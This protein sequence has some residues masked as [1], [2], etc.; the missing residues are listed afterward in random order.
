MKGFFPSIA[1]QLDSKTVTCSHIKMRVC[2][3]HNSPGT[4]S[5]K[6]RVKLTD[7]RKQ[8]VGFVK[9]HWLTHGVSPLM[10]FSGTQTCT[11]F[12]VRGSLLSHSSLPWSRTHVAKHTV[13]NT[14]IKKPGIKLVESRI[15]CPPVRLGLRPLPRSGLSHCR[16]RPCMP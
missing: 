14:P 4:V 5:R 12:S 7:M 9:C 15:T 2:V 10:D 1:P 3:F 11:Q 13:R 16:L 6:R 8:F